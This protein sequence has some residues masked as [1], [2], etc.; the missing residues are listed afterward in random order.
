MSNAT[1]RFRFPCILPSQAQ[2]E[3][4]RNEALVAIDAALHPAIVE[5]PLSAPSARPATGSVLA[6]CAGGDGALVRQRKSHRALDS[7]RL[8]IHGTRRF[9]LVFWKESAGLWICWTGTGWSEGEMSVSRLLIDGQQVVG[10]RQ[11]ALP[12]PSGGTTIDAEARASIMALIAAL[13][14]HGLTD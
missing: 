2:K 8:A 5:G 10:A 7:G 3:A 9:G 14:S 11:P 1:A 4:F 13:K 6:G 12:S